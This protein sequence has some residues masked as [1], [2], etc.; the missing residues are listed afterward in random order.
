MFH[1]DSR[2][3]SVARTKVFNGCTDGLN[4]CFCQLKK[5]PHI[6]KPSIGLCEKTQI[7]CAVTAQ[8]YTDQ[9]LC[10]RYKDN[11]IP[12]LLKFEISLFY[13]FSVSEKAGLR[14][15]WLEPLFFCHDD[16]H[17]FTVYLS[18]CSALSFSLCFFKISCNIDI[19]KYLHKPTS[20]HPS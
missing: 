19:A 4:L 20:P 9:R 12:L 18:A 15:T 2:P 13:I 1:F 3:T 17:I 8:L 10:F 11:L 7:R 16:G 6:R 14:R 5:E